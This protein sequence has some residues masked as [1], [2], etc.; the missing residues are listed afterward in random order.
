M[1]SVVGMMGVGCLTCQ[2]CLVYIRRCGVRQVKK[3]VSPYKICLKCL[4]PERLKFFPCSH[5]G[6]MHPTAKHAVLLACNREGLGA[7]HPVF[8]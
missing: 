3:I 4:T 6:L 7:V 2:K 1:T 5:S 8:L